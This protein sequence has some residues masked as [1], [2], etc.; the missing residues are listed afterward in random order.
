MLN[1]MKIRKILILNHEIDIHIV[2][3]LLVKTST[4]S[5]SFALCHIKTSTI[6]WITV[7]WGLLTFVSKEMTV[8]LIN[9]LPAEAAN[10]QA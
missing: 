8:S 9:K 10:D 4:Y 3:L 2:F 7:A 1:A 6:L 5:W